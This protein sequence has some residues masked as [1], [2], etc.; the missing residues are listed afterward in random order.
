MSKSPRKKDF[1]DFLT[2]EDGTDTFS[3]NVDK[4]LPLDAA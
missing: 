1:F 3:R 4:Q 2:V